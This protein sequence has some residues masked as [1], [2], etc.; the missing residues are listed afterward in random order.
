ML[1]FE[2]DYLEGAHEKILN[3]LIE[4]NM[5]K[6]PGYGAAPYCASAR[7]KI[8]DA[9]QCPEGE[10]FF[11]VGGTQTNATV[12]DG[13]LSSYEGVVSAETGHVNCHESG[14]IEASGHKVITLPHHEGK[15][16]AGE[17]EALLKTFWGDETYEHMVFPGMV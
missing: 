7:E 12:I 17:L 13:L 2:C 9:C 15:L 1:A 6:L 4:T 16:D 8:L 3:R 10:V 5:E 14:A 11:L